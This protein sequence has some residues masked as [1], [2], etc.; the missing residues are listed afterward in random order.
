MS[1]FSIELYF[2]KSLDRPEALRRLKLLPDHR[3]DEDRV[4]MGWSGHVHWSIAT[5]DHQYTVDRIQRYLGMSVGDF[6]VRLTI[7]NPGEDGMLQQ[8]DRALDLLDYNDDTI[9][10]YE[11]ADILFIQKDGKLTL[12]TQSDYPSD[13]LRAHVMRRRQA[14]AK[15]LGCLEELDS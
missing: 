14:E 11:L 3:P 13:F 1:S 6:S 8:W 9:A 5:F 7:H 15:P 4:D 12:D 10:L 2:P